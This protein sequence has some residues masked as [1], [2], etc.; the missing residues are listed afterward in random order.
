MIDKLLNNE[1]SNAALVVA[2]SGTIVTLVAS[3]PGCPSLGRVLSGALSNPV[4]RRE[5]SGEG[6]ATDEGRDPRA[7]AGAVACQTRRPRARSG[8]SPRSA[9]TNGPPRGEGRTF[10]SHGAHSRYLTRPTWPRA[11]RSSGPGT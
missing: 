5:S 10:G 4:P 11:G 2:L 7:L 6:A 1:A 8:G 9:C 3:G